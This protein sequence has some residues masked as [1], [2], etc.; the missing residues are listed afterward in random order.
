MIYQLVEIFFNVITPVFALVLIGYLAGPR[1]GLEARTL[2]RLAYFVLI[3][4][5]VFNVMSSAKMEAAL[6]T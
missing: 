3:P 4:S 1:L 6:A 2:S 5:F